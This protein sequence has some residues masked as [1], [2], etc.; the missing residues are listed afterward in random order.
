MPNRSM[1]ALLN[2]E[3]ALAAATVTSGVDG[4]IIDTQGYDSVMFAVTVT[5]LESGES[6]TLNLEDGEDSGLSDESQV[7][8]EF[9]VV[10]GSNNESDG[11][12]TL[13]LSFAD[14]DR[15]GT[16]LISY[17]GPKRYVRLGDVT[18]SG[19]DGAVISAVAIKGYPAHLPSGA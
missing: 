4:G 13:S 9:V 3:L 18:A 8:P 10:S 12:G 2:V 15:D 16:F 19:G 1:N 7:S 17:V 14:G 5:D 6:V 11:T